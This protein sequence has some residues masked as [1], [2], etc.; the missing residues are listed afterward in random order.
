MMN[1]NLVDC[2]D[3]LIGDVCSPLDVDRVGYGD[4]CPRKTNTI[5][6]AFLIVFSLG[7]LGFFCGP[8]LDAAASVW[9]QYVPGGTATLAS[10]M[11]GVGVA[12][13]TSL[14]GMDQIEAIYT[15]IVTGKKTKT[16]ETEDWRKNST[17]TNPLFL[18]F[19]DNN[20]LW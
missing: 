4:I 10:L 19:R 20:R 14:E 1:L 8:V 15:S 7:S 17:L 5:G 3:F 2:P 12:L 16:R 18:P 6:K 11:I 9:Q 13:F